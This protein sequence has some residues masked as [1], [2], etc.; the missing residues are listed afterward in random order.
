MVTE[1]PSIGASGKI[2]EFTSNP[3]G[4]AYT[5]QNTNALKEREIRNVDIMVLTLYFQELSPPYRNSINNF[6]QII[7]LDV[8]IKKSSAIP[9]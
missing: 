2:C 1:T 6:I 4:N 5:A 8:L 9:S 3:C 7:T